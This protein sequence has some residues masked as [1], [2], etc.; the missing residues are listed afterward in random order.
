MDITKDIIK[1]IDGGDIKMHSKIHYMIKRYG[2][3]LGIVLSF[4]LAI[5][6]FSY[7]L[8]A[9]DRESCLEMLEFGSRGFGLLMLS[10]PVLFFLIATFLIAAMVLMVKHIGQG[11]KRRWQFWFLV[12][13]V[14]SALFSFMFNALK[15]HPVLE[16]HLGPRSHMIEEAY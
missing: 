5:I 10:R 13:I 7:F 4:L 6:F 14:L 16:E 11:Y 9:C 2:L 3:V 12:V 8:Y 1:K 15:V